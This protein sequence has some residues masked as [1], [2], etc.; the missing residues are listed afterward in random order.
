M[1][2]IR[3]YLTMAS[4]LASSHY[5]F[6]RGWTIS[7]FGSRIS[8]ENAIDFLTVYDFVVERHYAP[9]EQR[10]VPGSVL[11]DIGANLGVVGNH[12]QVACV[13]DRG[14]H[15]HIDQFIQRSNRHQPRR[16]GRS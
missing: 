3:R 15:L 1:R 10:V 14:R 11:W 8:L 9:L 5:S 7:C 12:L 16:P 6:N 2:D 13:Q 4:L